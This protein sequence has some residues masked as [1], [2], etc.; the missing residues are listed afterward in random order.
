[1]GKY[2][3][4]DQNRR[5]QLSSMQRNVKKDGTTGQWLLV[6]NIQAF[7]DTRRQLLS[8]TSRYLLTLAVQQTPAQS[9]GKMRRS[10][11]CYRRMILYLSPGMALLIMQTWDSHQH[12]QQM[13][14]PPSP[15]KVF[16]W[17]H[18]ATFINLCPSGQSQLMV[19]G[20]LEK[21]AREGHGQPQKNCEKDQDISTMEQ[22]VCESV[23][24]EL[25]CKV[26]Q[27]VSAEV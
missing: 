5:I 15:A 11:R 19:T 4:I 16:T 6:S 17:S 12:K 18:E 10:A 9:G 14:T 1:M 21:L 23:R 8:H 20:L 26:W 22:L 24:K 7:T 13:C 3:S 27:A 25:R 2:S